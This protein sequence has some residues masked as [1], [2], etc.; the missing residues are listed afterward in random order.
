MSH[1][2][3]DGHGASARCILWHAPDSAIPEELLESL[4]RRS[5]RIA[6]CT[7][8]FSAVG[9]ACRHE[10]AAR[11]EQDEGPTPEPLV[12]LL[13][14]PASLPRA[15]EVVAA[16]KRYAPRA[17]C[18]CYER[19]ANQALRAVVESDVT[20]WM[21]KRT[22]AT[23]PAG[24]SPDAPI[25]NGQSRSPSPRAELRLAGQADSGAPGSDNPRPVG[26]IWTGMGFGVGVPNPFLTRLPGN[27]PTHVGN[28]S[29]TPA[30]GVRIVNPDATPST[31]AAGLLT[32]EELAMLLRDEPLPDDLH[33]PDEDNG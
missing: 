21:N 27:V 32:D 30:P 3:G 10:Q 11:A 4:S 25:S 17:A 5:V 15:P 33:I 6:P 20:A 23:A 19:G 26:E 18:W 2:P 12:L 29:P 7:S 31:S 8:P 28:V 13:V 16:L 24:T 1:A 22:S 9:M 14:F